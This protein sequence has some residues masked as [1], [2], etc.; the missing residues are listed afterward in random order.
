[1][2]RFNGTWVNG[3]GE[4]STIVT[5][6]DGTAIG[7]GPLAASEAH[8]GQV[9]GHTQPIRVEKTRPADATPYA[10]NDIINESA[11]AGTP[12]TVAA[13]R[14]GGPGSG[15]VLGFLLQTDQAA[16]VAQCEIDVYDAAPA[17]AVNDNAEATHLYA[18]SGKLLQTVL[19]P[20]LAKKTA[21]S[22]MAEAY[23][24][25][26]VAFDAVDAT[27]I[28]LRLRTLTIFTPASGQKLKI[29]TFCSQ[30]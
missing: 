3:S 27:N 19:L 12:W 21:A 22:D 18:D 13:A 8:V 2:P 30:D 10:V 6:E 25:C 17:V 24:P 7:S 15:I 5:N 16:C 26:A 29:T 20:A 28:Y 4:G 11:S 1:M 14:S 23:A 9:G